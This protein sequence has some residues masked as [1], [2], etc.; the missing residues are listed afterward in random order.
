MRLLLITVGALTNQIPIMLVIVA[1]L[2]NFEALRRL[3]VF[4]SKVENNIEANVRSR[5]I[6][7]DHV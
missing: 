2:A 1:V 3:I 4:K 7:E 6:L 5:I